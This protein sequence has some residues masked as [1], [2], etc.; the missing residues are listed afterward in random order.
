MWVSECFEDHLSIHSTSKQANMASLQLLYKFN[1]ACIFW[2]YVC[3]LW[4]LGWDMTTIVLALEGKLLIINGLV[5]CTD[6]SQKKKH[7]WQASIFKQCSRFLTPRKW[8]LKLLYN[9]ISSFSERPSSRMARRACD[10]GY[11]WQ[12]AEQSAGGRGK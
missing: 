6:N 9:S 4:N 7:K 2:Y 3:L 1:P 5:N 10:D 8:I 12:G 11:M